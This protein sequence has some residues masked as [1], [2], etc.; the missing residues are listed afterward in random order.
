MTPFCVILE[1]FVW[2]WEAGAPDALFVLLFIFFD[3][4]DRA[5]FALNPVA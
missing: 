4:Q 3:P 2:S 1:Q 5:L